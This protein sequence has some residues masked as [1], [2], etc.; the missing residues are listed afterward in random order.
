MHVFPS[1]RL[2]RAAACPYYFLPKPIRQ[3]KLTPEQKNALYLP[4]RGPLCPK[5][6]SDASATGVHESKAVD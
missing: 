4:A 6:S 3:A 2:S 1:N 5:M